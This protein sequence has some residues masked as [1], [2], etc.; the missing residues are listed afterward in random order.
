MSTL[1]LS[2]VLPLFHR[3]E[4]FEAQSLDPTEN[5]VKSCPRQ[6]IE[7]FRV[8]NEVHTCLSTQGKGIVM[9]LL[10]LRQVRQQT[11]SIAAISDKI[12]IHQ[13]HGTSPAKI[14]EQL[15]LTDHLGVGL[16]P[17]DAA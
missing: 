12:I 10:P 7:E 6:G 1:G 3:Q 8:L 2:G 16:G 4:R 9:R 17:R 5:Q 13:E 15:K 14:V 11:Q